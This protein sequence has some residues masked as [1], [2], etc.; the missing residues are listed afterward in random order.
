MRKAEARKVYKERRVALTQKEINIRQDLLLIKF[1]E[2]SLPYAQIV[3]TYLPKY[4]SNEPDP[5]P[6]VDWMRFRDLGLKVVY[7]K[8]NPTNFSMQHFLQDDDMVFEENQFGIP[9]P[10]SGVEISSE[11]IDIVFVPLLA[12][13]E[14]GN[15]VGYGKGYYD[16]FLATC[17]E[18]VVTVGLSYFPPLSK[19]DDIDFFDKKIDFCITPECVYAF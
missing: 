15:R 5:G 7:A 16:R 9:E 18:D 1:Q 8:I 14:M 19:I 10:I 6:L 13:D 4:A 11:W 2:L 17:R 3:H 12:F